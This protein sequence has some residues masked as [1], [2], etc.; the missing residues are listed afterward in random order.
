MRAIGKR[1][2]DTPEFY[3]CAAHRPWEKGLNENTDGLIREYFPKGTDFGA[4][5]DE[6]VARVC[7]AINRRPRKRLDWRMPQE[8]HCSEV[9]HL[10]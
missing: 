6:E 4:V 9:L 5:T 1:D 7:D 8:A 2:L 3:F 10:L